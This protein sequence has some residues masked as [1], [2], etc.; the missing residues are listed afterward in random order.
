[1]RTVILSA[2]WCIADAINKNWVA[3]DEVGFLATIFLVA[4]A[5]D[6]TEF[7]LKLIRK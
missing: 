7:I 5:M 4:V 3:K 2:G 6:V 1:M